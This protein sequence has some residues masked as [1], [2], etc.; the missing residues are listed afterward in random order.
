MCCLWCCGFGAAVSDSAG[1]GY[2]IVD[3]GYYVASETASY[4]LVVLLV[5]VL[6]L[7]ALLVVVMEAVVLDFGGV[8][9]D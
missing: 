4:V 2:G 3:A 7:M 9:C 6:V 1:V 5:I 8:C